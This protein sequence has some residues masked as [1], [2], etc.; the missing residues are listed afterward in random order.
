MI[1]EDL[2]WLD[3]ASEAFLENLAEM[4]PATRTL[5]LVNFRPEYHAEWMQHSHYQQLSLLPLGAAAV[6]ELL[7]GLLGSH[8]SLADLGDRIFAHTG[9]N[10]FF[11]EEVVR[12]LAESGE[13]TGEAG[14]Y[15]LR[16]AVSELAIPPNVQALLAARIDRLRLGDRPALRGADPAAG[17]RAL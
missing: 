13:L 17:R 16:G 8:P 1:F 7:A 12:S 4:V 5:L 11:V 14:A 9:G 2:H 10:P 3:G 15:R 6:R